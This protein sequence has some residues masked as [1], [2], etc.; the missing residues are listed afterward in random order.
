LNHPHICALYDIGMQDGIDF[1]VV[2][3][4]KKLQGHLCELPG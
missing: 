4:L 3:V 1:L 2:S